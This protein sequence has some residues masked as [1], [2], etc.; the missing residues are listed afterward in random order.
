MR[1]S[2]NHS[3][4]ITFR[5]SISEIISSE[6][7]QL[8]FIS[9]DTTVLSSAASLKLTHPL[10]LK[11]GSIYTSFHFFCRS[12]LF[13]AVI[14]TAAAVVNHGLKCIAPGSFIS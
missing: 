14:Y 10:H 6:I 8:S 9:A 2:F 12:I 11:A 7:R 3:G 13:T 1:Q 5:L 4:K